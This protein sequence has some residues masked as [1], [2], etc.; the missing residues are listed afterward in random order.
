MNARAS[1]RQ[2]FRARAMRWRRFATS[3]PSGTGI[4]KASGAR[5]PRSRRRCSATSRRSG[6]PTRPRVPP[7]PRGGPPPRVSPSWFVCARPPFRAYLQHGRGP[8]CARVPQEAVIGS[9]EGRL[10]QL[11]SQRVAENEG[12][13]EVTRQVRR[14]PRVSRLPR[15]ARPC[16]WLRPPSTPPSAQLHE[17]RAAKAEA[18]TVAVE[19]RAELDRCESLDQIDCPK[20]VARRPSPSCQAR[21]RTAAAA[22][23]A[24]ATAAAAA[25]AAPGTAAAV[26]AA[27]ARA[28]RGRGGGSAAGGSASRGD[29]DGVVGASGCGL[30]H[31]S[32]G[33]ARRVIQSLKWIASRTLRM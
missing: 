2:R 30:V 20:S 26:A 29:G 13:R 33:A 14:P 27:L 19:L 5:S 12:F 24:A 4:Y 25:A 10:A 11:E 16:N 18:T 22:A 23:A 8:A 21:G 1:S 28:R 17:E 9:L 32:C 3:S 7:R 31:F 6:R 15:P